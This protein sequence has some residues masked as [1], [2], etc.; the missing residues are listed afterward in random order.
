MACQ[1]KNRILLSAAAAFSFC[2]ISSAQGEENSIRNLDFFIGEWRGEATLSYPREEGREP[3]E[4]TVAVS[5]NYILKDTY[6][7]C[8]TAWTR[9]DGRTRTFRLH[10]NHIEEDNVFQTLFIYDNYPHHVSYPL[11]FDAK[12]NAYLGSSDFEMDD[13]VAGSERIVWRVS[14]DGKEISCEEFN[15]LETDPDDFWPRNFQ[16]TWRK[17]V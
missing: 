2:T 12:T 14:E 11:R 3:R 4:E 6:I 10:F 1:M 16:F 15:H 17:V 7:Q 9:A 8:D 13:G 5:C